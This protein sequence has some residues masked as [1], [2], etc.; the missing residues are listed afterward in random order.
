MKSA[1]SNA[2][3]AVASSF[4]RQLNAES[5][6]HQSAGMN[7]CR[8][9]DWKDSLYDQPFIFQQIEMDHY[10]IT[11]TVNKDEKFHCQVPVIRLYGV[12]MGKHSVLC[13][14][15]GFLPYFYVRAPWSGIG[16]PVDIE[17]FKVILEQ[18]IKSEE[19][20]SKPG[21][22]ISHIEPVTKCSIYGYNE[23][24]DQCFL[25]IYLFNPNNMAA[26]KRI[27]EGGVEF[28]GKWHNFSTFES[29][30]PHIMR[31]MV[32]SKITGMSWVKIDPSNLHLR[33]DSAYSS[34]C[35]VEFDVFDW[36]MVC[37][38]PLDGE[39]ASVAPLRILSF[40]IECAGRKG[41]FPDSSIDPVI[42]IA[43]VLTV[44]GE[45]RSHKSVFT[46][47]TCSAIVG[48]E[49]R[50]FPSEAQLLAAWN[51][52]FLKADPDVII[53]YN[54]L[55]FDFPYLLGR[56]EALKVH[57]FP[58]LGRIIENSSRAKDAIFSS[59]A[60][61]TRESKTVDIDGR[62]IFDLLQVCQREF[63]LRSYSLNSVSAEFLGEQKEDVPHTIITDLQAGNADTRRRLA[64]YCLKDAVLPQR[65]MDKLMLFINYV[66]MSRV[67]GVPFNFLLSRG[68]QI[69][70]VSQLYRKAAEENYIIPAL[71]SEVAEEQYEGATV[72]EPARGYYDVPIATLDFTSLYPSI[73]IAHNLCYTTLLS[74]EDLGKMNSADYEQSPSGDY[75]VKAHLRAGI[76]PIVLQDLLAARKRAK[77]LLKNETDPARKAVFNA[78]QLAIKISANSV[79]GFTGA[80]VGKLPCIPISQS[81]TAYGR[82]MIEETKRLI[83]EKFSIANGYEWDAKVIYGDTDSVMV[84]FGCSNLERVMEMGRE[85]AAFVTKHFTKPVNLDFE[86]CYF[87]FLLINKKRYAGLYWT[88]AQ[89]YDKMDTK[90]LETV[91]RDNCKLVQTVVDTCLRKILI[92]RD[93]EGAKAYAKQVIADLLQG[94]IDLSQLV[95]SKQ[96]SKSGEDYSA[97]QAHVELAE[98]MRKRDA[99]SAPALGDRVAYVIIK[100]S[101]G[102][103]AYEKS[104]DPI[105]VLENN[106]PIDT[107]YYLDNQLSKPL[108]RIFEPIVANSDE[109]LTGDHTRIVNTATNTNFSGVMKGFVKKSLSCLGCKASLSSKDQTARRAVC[110]FCRKDVFEV[111]QRNLVAHNQLELSFSRLWSQCQRCQKDLHHD[112]LCTSRDCPIF[113]MRKKIQK[114]LKESS[115][116]IERF[117]GNEW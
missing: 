53:G 83:E 15:H 41:T 48:A 62:I 81:T 4:E 68:Q 44:Q 11:D 51:D 117:S 35:Q 27:L 9:E 58:F 85:G 102:A 86:K 78:R 57:S 65:L 82:T 116:V 10:M 108:M 73:M 16:S 60:Y 112:V 25:K 54:I 21:S 49:V 40:D 87:P 70:V 110:D 45:E 100:A 96:L 29:N 39:W 72:I 91:R 114:S 88:N 95:I 42:Q 101:K 50:S 47:D 84:N 55:N 36:M 113:Y 66:E 17:H 37:P 31:F 67:T 2:R 63:K 24:R 20:S 92:H 1:L 18:K 98:R 13:H 104:E 93:V 99:G 56:A 12:T 19:R 3:N 79:Y 8:T 74:K 71:K 111:Y 103:A 22:Y 52:F 75:F 23:E 97:K 76:L 6:M 34:R 5:E 30:I 43:N 28:G 90:G 7:I 26:M 46:L 109:L 106:L 59:K 32:D 94:K 69:K 64:V 105:Y 33:K 115:E 38:L 80:T 77:E 107:K 89:K 14:I 61:G